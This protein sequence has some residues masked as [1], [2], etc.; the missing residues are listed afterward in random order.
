MRRV[1]S[2][3]CPGVL[4]TVER[5]RDVWADQ[6][7]VDGVVMG[8]MRALSMVLAEPS[9]SSRKVRRT[10]AT[11]PPKLVP[12]ISVLP[13]LRQSIKTRQ[14][15]NHLLSDFSHVSRLDAG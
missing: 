5:A 10:T 14:R 2:L 7:S 15:F 12:G 3:L 13:E 1:G 6:T 11:A 8:A 9:Q 4:L